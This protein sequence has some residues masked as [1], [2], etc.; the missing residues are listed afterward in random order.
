M[1]TRIKGLDEYYG[2]DMEGDC[3]RWEVLVLAS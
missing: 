3:K 2:E 1:E